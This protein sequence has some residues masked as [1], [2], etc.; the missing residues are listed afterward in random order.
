MKSERVLLEKVLG[1]ENPAD[2]FT[3]Y[4]DQ[5][6][7]AMALEKMHREFREGRAAQALET[8]GLKNVNPVE[9]GHFDN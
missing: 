6:V 4:L 3:K 2:L 5:S 9:K 1:S 7:M 8:M